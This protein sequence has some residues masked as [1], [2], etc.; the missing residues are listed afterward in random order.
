MK[1]NRNGK[2]CFMRRNSL[3][4]VERSIFYVGKYV[5]QRVLFER[6]LHYVLH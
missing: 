5:M 6:L 3:Q 1:F 2:R 4:C